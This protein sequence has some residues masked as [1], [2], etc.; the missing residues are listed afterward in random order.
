MR[1]RPIF[2]G[3][4]RRCPC[5]IRAAEE[6]TADF[7][8]M[9]DHLALALLTDRSDSLNGAFKAVEGV[10]CPS[11]HQ[12]KGFVVVIPAYLTPCHKNLLPYE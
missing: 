3:G 6:A 7:D 11:R 4:S 1:L 5:A 9:P 12:L 10:P 8:A 2:D